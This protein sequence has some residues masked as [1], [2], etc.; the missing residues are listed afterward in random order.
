[1]NVVLVGA[2]ASGK[3][4]VQNELIKKEPCF[5]KVV[6]YTTRP[7]RTGEVNGVDYNFVSVEEFNALIDKDFFVEYNEY[8]DWKYGTPKSELQ[9]ENENHIIV[10]TPAGFRALKKCNIES[11]SVYINV[12]RRSRLINNLKRGDNIEEAYRRSLS[13]VGQFDGVANEVDIVVDNMEYKHSIEEMFEILLD[14]ITTANPNFR[15]KQLSIFND[16]TL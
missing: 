16:E 4:A 12:D 9:N 15:C 8:R 5:K 7:P 13:D 3:S 1:M 14:I 6:T 11:L 2:S 10:L